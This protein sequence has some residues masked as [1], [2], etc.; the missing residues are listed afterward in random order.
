[1]CKLYKSKTNVLSL[2]SVLYLPDTVGAKHQYKLL[3]CGK[4]RNKSN[5]NKSS[6]FKASLGW[7]IFG[8]KSSILKKLDFMQIRSFTLINFSELPQF[9]AQKSG[10]LCLYLIFLWVLDP[11]TSKKIEWNIFFTRFESDF[12]LKNQVQV[13]QKLTR[14]RLFKNLPNSIHDSTWLKV[15]EIGDHGSSRPTGLAMTILEIVSI[16]FLLA[17]C[18]N[19]F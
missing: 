4:K 18:A 1:M 15:F 13:S 17:V 9:L 5:E 6:P 8:S 10:R 7:D 3:L 12:S 14:S 11:K 19:D 2:F 16:L